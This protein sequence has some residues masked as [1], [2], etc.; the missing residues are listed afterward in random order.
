MLINTVTPSEFPLQEVEYIQ[1]SWTQ[2][3][4]TWFIPSNTSKVQVS[5][6]W[7]TIVWTWWVLFWARY[8]WASNWRWFLISYNN[9]NSSYQFGWTYSSVLPTWWTSWDHTLEIS[10]TWVYIDWNL[11]STPSTVTFTS[12]VSMT[13]FCDNDN[14]TKNEYS[15]YKLYTF[16]IWDNWTLVMDFVPCYRKS[17]NVIWLYDI[18]NDKFYTNAGSWTFT[19]WPDVN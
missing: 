14:W 10:Q 8:A 2:Y 13:I 15:S 18:V 6:W 5:M 4:D 9:G 1:S 3:I 16:K 19:K 12:P 17:D 7:F 11:A